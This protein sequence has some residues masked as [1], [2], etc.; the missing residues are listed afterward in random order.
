MRLQLPGVGNTETPGDLV[1][2]GQVPDILVLQVKPVLPV[3]INPLVGDQAEDRDLFLREEVQGPE[4]IGPA[5]PA[6]M[7]N[8]HRAGGLGILQGDPHYTGRSGGGIQHEEVQVRPGDD[9]RGQKLLDVG[10]GIIVFNLN[11]FAGR[12][13]K[14][15]AEHVK[16]VHLDRDQRVIF[17]PAQSRIFSVQDDRDTRCPVIQVQDTNPEPLSVEGLGN[18]HRYSGFPDPAL[19]RC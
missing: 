7:G 3:L 9:P 16:P 19:N 8:H 13:Y 17:S 10:G 14:R 2:Q 12:P 18:P 6:G 15:H 4:G 5:H 1:A 11:T